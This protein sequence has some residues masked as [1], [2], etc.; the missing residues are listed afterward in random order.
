VG[1]YIDLDSATAITMGLLSKGSRV[2]IPTRLADIETKKLRS[3][4]M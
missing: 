1:G 3:A 2:P 4:C